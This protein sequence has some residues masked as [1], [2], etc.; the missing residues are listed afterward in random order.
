MT[1]SKNAKRTTLNSIIFASA[2]VLPA[3]MGE[4]SHSTESISEHKSRVAEFITNQGNELASYILGKVETPDVILAILK[5]ATKQ[6]PAVQKQLAELEAK[7]KAEEEAKRKAEEE[8][9]N[10]EKDKMLKILTDSGLDL[11]IAQTMVAAGL[12]AKAPSTAPKNRYERVPVTVDGKEYEVPVRGN[13]SEE[14]KV[15]VAND[16]GDREAFITKYRTD[17]VKSTEV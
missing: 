2:P 4:E 7:A 9:L 14:L 5:E 10:A 16:G 13:I 6:V 12:K 11:A 15:L 8:A 17:A 3:V 1:I